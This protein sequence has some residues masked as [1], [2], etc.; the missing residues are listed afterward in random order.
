MRKMPNLTNVTVLSESRLIHW[1]ELSLTLLRAVV[2]LSDKC[3][4]FVY[5]L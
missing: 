1:T 4:N 2:S 5:S 3:L